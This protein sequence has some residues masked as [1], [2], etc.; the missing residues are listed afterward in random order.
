MPPDAAACW[1]VS[2]GAAGATNRRTRPS[3]VA[4]DIALRDNSHGKD[5]NTPAPLPLREPCCTEAEVE[6]LVHD[7]YA[8]VRQDDLLGPVFEQHV[9]DWPAHMA[10]LVDFWSSL[11]RG[12]QRFSGAPMGIHM[13]L[14]GLNETLFRRWLQLFGQT[15]ASLG[16]PAMQQLANA[17]AEMIANRFWQRYQV[18]GRDGSGLV[19]L[20]LP[21][22]PR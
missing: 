11:L 16:N 9:H 13:A 20:P 2:D 8:S 15:T 14:P 1:P 6:R 19:A 5:M 10:R 18:E 4:G 3:G 21:L 7:F 22:R 17:R 12:T